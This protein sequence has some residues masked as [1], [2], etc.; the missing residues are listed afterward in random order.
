MF[1]SHFT[2]L[3][4][5]V[6]FLSLHFA[7]AQDSGESGE[8]LSKKK[9]EQTVKLAEDAL[10]NAERAQRHGDTPGMERALENYS[11][12]MN[13]LERGIHE[14]KVLHDEREDVAEIVAEATS[15][16]TS[17][18]QDLKNKVP[19]QGQKGI[20][21]ALE[22]SQRGHDKALE[23][24]SKKRRE[25]LTK[26]REMQRGPSSRAPSSRSNSSLRGSHPSTGPGTV[27]GPSRGGSQ[28]GAGRGRH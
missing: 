16:H 26:R 17:V 11:R 8:P 27:R 10:G 9:A 22:A 2:I 6:A 7:S 24:L 13:K 25:E 21:H 19:S 28:R 14:G 15:K 20:D 12:H 1:R 3:L 18:L 4:I 23:N 5:T